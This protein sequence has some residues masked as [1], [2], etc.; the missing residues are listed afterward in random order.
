[1]IAL[2]SLVT[3]ALQLSHLDANI[4]SAQEF[5]RLLR[6][7]LQAYVDA[8]IG[9]NRIVEYELLRDGPT[10]SGAAYPKYYVWVKASHLNRTVLAGAARVAAVDRARFEVTHF[11]SA[12][13]INLSPSALQDFPGCP[14]NGDPGQGA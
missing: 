14:A 8:R 1:L 3:V 2:L 11:L 12:E 9:A 10:Q 5:D 6:R 13:E 7:D 4:P